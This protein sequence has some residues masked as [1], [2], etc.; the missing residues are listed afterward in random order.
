[1]KTIT[2]LLSL[3]IVMPIWYY[4]IY[5]ILVRVQATELMWFLFWVYV[6]LV[7][8][9]RIIVDLTDQKKTNG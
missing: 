9:I 1:M 3:F 8:F 6:P 2:G 4:L 7:V 5:Q